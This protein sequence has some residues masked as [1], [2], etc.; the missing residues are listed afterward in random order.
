MSL[1]KREL[2]FARLRNNMVRE[3]LV[4]RNIKDKK[5]LDAMLKV[6]RHLF[7]SENLVPQAYEDHPLPIGFGQTISQPYIVALMTELLDIQGGGIILEIGTGSGYQTAILAEIAGRVFTMD[8]C[9]E[10]SRNAEKLLG[11]L[12]YS[13]VKFKSGNGYEGW[14]EFAPYGGIMAAC[15]PEKIPQTLVEQVKEGGR[16][17]IPVGAY[18]QTLKLII[19]ESNNIKEKDAASVSFVPMTK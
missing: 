1:F 14:K 15:A 10:L 13:N 3:Q 5:V 2:D 18:F 11:E 4:K 6:E 8:S 9:P 12:G 7:V 16:I 19:K 17:V